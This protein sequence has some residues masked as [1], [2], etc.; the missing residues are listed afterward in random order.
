MT[1]LF[2][3][4]GKIALV[5]GGSRGL[6]RAIALGLADH[7][8]DIAIVSRKLENCEA[9]ARKVE[10]RGRRAL[11][12]AG[13]MGRWDEIEAVVE[14]AYAHFGR[15][16]ILVNNAGM[17]PMAASSL[18]TPEKLVDAVLALNFKGPMRMSALVGSRMAAGDGGC[19]INIS[20]AGSIRPTPEIIPYAGAKAA[21]NAM[22]VAHAQEY[23]PKVRVNAVL[24][25]SFRTD[26]AKY[27]PADKE[28]STPAALK[29][30]G[31]PEEI[32]TTILYLCSDHSG[33]TT[34]SMIR[35]DGGRP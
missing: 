13:H 2:D 11:A 8:A 35:V 20:S 23:A 27:W 6:G 18:E 22:T 21:L 7:G 14:R 10:Q 24:P 5:T 31:E 1:G 28:A 9:V 12:L 16:D 32:V 33:F 30:F 4:S 25:G 17:S 34:G 26:V 3:L 15:L 29:R 19:I